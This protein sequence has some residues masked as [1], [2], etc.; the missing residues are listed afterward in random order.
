MSIQ[1]KTMVVKS[2]TS[3]AET[4]T[5]IRDTVTFDVSKMP[6]GITYKGLK[7][8]LS[9]A[10]P[11]QWNKASTY[12]A[13]TVVWDDATHASY[14]SK[15]RVPQNIELTNEFYWLRTADLDAQVEMYR[16]EVMEFDGRITENA[17]AI[18]A[19]TARAEEIEHTLTSKVDTL[20]NATKTY[21]IMGDSWTDPTTNLHHPNYF[22]WCKNI[23]DA[24]ANVHTFGHG[25]YNLTQILEEIDEAAADTSF[26]NESV[27]KIYVVACVNEGTN[28]PRVKA[29]K[30]NTF[31]DKAKS[32]FKNADIIWAMNTYTCLSDNWFTSI[33]SCSDILSYTS[34][35]F[36]FIPLPYIMCI[37]AMF[38]HDENDAAVNG[39]K[40]FG[41]HPSDFA[42]PILERLAL[43][44]LTGQNSPLFTKV[45]GSTDFGC[46]VRLNFVVRGESSQLVSVDVPK[47]SKVHYVNLTEDN[48]SFNTNVTIAS[49][50]IGNYGLGS[51]DCNLEDAPNLMIPIPF[52]KNGCKLTDSLRIYNYSPVIS[53]NYD[54]NRF[55]LAD[56][57]YLS[58]TNTDTERLFSFII[59]A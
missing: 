57:S 54:N 46:D 23:C 13:L 28:E 11:I 51:V 43:N 2:D 6:N 50:N 10:E 26:T 39:V 44:V 55:K 16:Q 37:P 17:Q 12:D 47:E 59:N 24:Y 21:L 42:T 29:D 25:G 40:I 14:A 18:A 35:K 30:M 15:R 1:T 48:V 19:E 20:I 52:A 33:S 31:C 38:S 49:T 7:A 32:V 3:L 8:V 53:H 34:N 5:T 41:F 22:Q 56:F 36:T 27:D 4:S 45:G 58:L 9:F